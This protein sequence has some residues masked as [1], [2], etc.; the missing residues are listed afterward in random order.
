[1][2]QSTYNALP[3]EVSKLSSDSVALVEVVRDA[4]GKRHQ[5]Q[6]AYRASVDERGQR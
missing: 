3:L 4:G 1:M 5:A 6:A 2:E